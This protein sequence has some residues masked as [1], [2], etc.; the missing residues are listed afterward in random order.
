MRTL[1][2]T[3]VL[4]EVRK[5]KPD[6]GVRA[7][8]ES[9][10]ADDFFLSVVTIGE[11]VRGIALLKKS[12]RRSSLEAWVRTI[13]EEHAER[14]LPVDARIARLWGEIDAT[15]KKAGLAMAV[16]DGL[17]AATALHHDLVLMTRNTADLLSVDVRIDNPWEL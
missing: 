9:I 10:P 16:A 3:C 12:K 4:S 11:L 8:L 13:E 5:P 6:G 2:D 14:V 7:K 1:I 17:I 15:A